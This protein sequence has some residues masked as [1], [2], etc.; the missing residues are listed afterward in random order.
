ME[1]L[2]GRYLIDYN[3]HGC[4][5]LDISLTFV[6]SHGCTSIQTSST[7]STATLATPKGINVY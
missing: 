5:L 2:K 7:E 6:M 3:G 1:S 4:K